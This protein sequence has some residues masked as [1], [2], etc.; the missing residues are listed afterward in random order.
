MVKNRSSNRRNPAVPRHSPRDLGI[1]LAGDQRIDPGEAQVA[2]AITAPFRRFLRGDDGEGRIDVADVE[3]A[4]TQMRTIGDPRP[5][6]G[7]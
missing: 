4:T 1:G 3:A 5:L 6:T 7:I 2:A